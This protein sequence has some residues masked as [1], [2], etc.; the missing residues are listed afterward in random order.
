DG[1]DF[2]MF[3]SYE[4]GRQDYVTLIANYIPLEDAYGGPN[5][6]SLDPDGLYEIEI[7]N[8]GDAQEHVTF[9][10]RFTNTYQ[11]VA[12]AI[13]GAAVARPLIN[14]G[15]FGPGVTDGDAN[16][17]LIESYTVTVT[18]GG[19]RNDKGTLATNLTSGGTTFRKPLD[20]IGNKS[21]PDYPT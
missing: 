1:T 21:I 13:G 19:R 4:A 15:P 5:Y 17:N 3:R 9:Q 11:N 10:F 12:L 8:Q 14:V 18:H 6:F 20:N 7:D 16:K 2:Y